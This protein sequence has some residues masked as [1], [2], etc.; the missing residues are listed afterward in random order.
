MIYTIWDKAS[1]INGVS[2]G[3]MMEL[4]GFSAE[5]AIYLL[6]DATGATHVI[7]SART[8]PFPAGSIEESAALH[9]A[10]MERPAPPPGESLEEYRALVAGLQEVIDR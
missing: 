2:A 5:D 6:Q 9:L 7:E 4:K 1:P 3:R 10:A 8:T